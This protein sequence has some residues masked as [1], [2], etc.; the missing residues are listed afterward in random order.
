[1]SFYT[2]TA[3]SWVVPLVLLLLAL[4]GRRKINARYPP[5]PHPLPIV[6]NILDLPRIHIGR[7]FSALSKQFGDV[8]H[9]SVFGRDVVVLGSL[10]AARD[11]LEKRSANY[12]DRPTSVMVQLTGSDWLIPLMNY[13]TLWR[14]H[15]R[16]VRSILSP[17]SLSHYEA[18]QVDVSRRLLRL[19]VQS[20]QELESHIEFTFAALAIGSIY[21]LDMHDQH[22]EHYGMTERMSEIVVTLMNPKNFPVEAFQ[23]LLHLPS[24]LPGA[25]FKKWAA[26]AKRDTLYIADHLFHAAKD[27]VT[28]KPSTRSMVSLLLEYSVSSG[29]KGAELEKLRKGVAASAHTGLDALHAP[30]GAFFFAMARFPGAQK[31]AQAELDAVVGTRRLPEFSDRPSLPYTTALVKEVLR[32]HSPGPVGSPRQVVADD[33]YGGYLIPGGALIFANIWAI[34]H[35]PEVFPE[36]EDFKPERFLNSA[37]TVDVHGREPADVAFGFG[38]RVCPG[39]HFA[40]STLFILF[41]SL[42]SAF[43]IA[44]PMGE[45]GT[46]LEVIWEAT[47]DLIVSQPKFHQYSIKPRSPHV[48][49]LVGLAAAC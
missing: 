13:G 40:D 15:H 5:G 48:G 41:A 37:G 22:D 43:E 35:D 18:V 27:I 20:P 10:K 1:M 17:Q 9:L 14:Q 31:R 25:G 4:R 26:D 28:S 45:D 6:G 42:L 39:R 49:Q 29:M 33:E 23:V 38:R 16:A 21:G 34:L 32:W 12:S 30:M 36:P 11:L 24:R 8:V 44:P 46:P 19:L 3:W 7:E 2:Q 47:D